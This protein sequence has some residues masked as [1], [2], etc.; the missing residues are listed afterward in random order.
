MLKGGNI[1]IMGQRIKS[2]RKERGFTQQQ[3]GDMI[4]VTK[5]SVCGYEKGTR[6]PNLDTLEDLASVFNSTTDYLL[7]RDYIIKEPDSLWSIAFSKDDKNIIENLKMHPSLYNALV[8]DGK[9]T[10]ELI[11]KKFKISTKV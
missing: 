8:N 6:I 4:N 1:M 9:R 3:L 10:I 5:V 2:L 11:D 7:G